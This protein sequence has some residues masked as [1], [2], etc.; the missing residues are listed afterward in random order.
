[1][2]TSTHAIDLG[3]VMVGSS[4]GTQAMT[5]NKSG[6]DGTYYEVRTSGAATSTVSGRYNAFAMDSVGSKMAT[7]G[8]NGSTATAGLKSGSVTVDNLDITTQGGAGKGANDADDV[9]NIRATVLEHANPSFAAATD[10]NSVT[11]NFGNLPQGS[12]THSMTFD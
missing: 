6:V 4:L 7:L 1:I 9:I 11:L 3:R 5:I 8:L 12:G 2:S 10:T